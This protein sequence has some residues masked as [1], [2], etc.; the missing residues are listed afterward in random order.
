MDL[1]DILAVAVPTV[2][3]IG[4]VVTLI[5]GIHATRATRDNDREQ[6]GRTVL[7]AAAEPFARSALEALTLLR[8]VTPPDP[9]RTRSRPHRNEGLL[10]DQAGLVARLAECRA[11]LDVV[12]VDRA[13]VRLAFNPASYPAEHSR[14]VLFQ[15][16]KALSTAEDYYWEHA[17]ASG[18][19]A[20]RSSTGADL[21]TVYGNHRDQ[22]YSALDDF[23]E[24]VG[25]RLEKPTWHLADIPDHPNWRKGSGATAEARSS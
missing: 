11:A 7:I 3:L 9:T 8:H 16:R 5:T 24:E 10:T 15:L 19:A 17:E 13:Q 23:F 21:R 20:W 2:A 12:R 1:T 14:E 18:A 6:V 22:A 25:K 4:V